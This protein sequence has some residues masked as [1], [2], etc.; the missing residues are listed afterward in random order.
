MGKRTLSRLR[1]AYFLAVLVQSPFCHSRTGAPITPL[2]VV[3][4]FV[5]VQ[6]KESGSEVSGA[7]LELSLIHI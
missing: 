3:A 7:A 1:L 2:Q 5:L 4:K 6:S